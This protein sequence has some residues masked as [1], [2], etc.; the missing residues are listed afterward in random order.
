MLFGIDSLYFWLAVII[1]SIAAEAATLGLC[2][3]WFAAGGAAA[4]AVLGGPVG[5][6]IGAI[7]FEGWAATPEAAADADAGSEE[8]AVC[9]SVFPPPQA[10]RAPSRKA[11]VRSR[12]NSRFMWHTP[13]SL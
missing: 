5:A 11:Q 13:V 8:D 3:I 9:G 7:L 10:V 6:I 4:G 1:I 2:G 12:E